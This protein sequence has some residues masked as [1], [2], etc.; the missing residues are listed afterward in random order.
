MALFSEFDLV[1]ISYDEPLKEERWAK[2]LDTVPW[3]KRV[4]GVK[5][6][7]AAHKA[8]AALSET[9]HFFT[10]DGDNEL[11]GSVHNIQVD[12]GPR[13]LLG[14]RILSWNAINAVNGLVYG[15]GGLKFWPKQLALDMRTHEAAE[16]QANGIEF[17]W[18]DRYTHLSEAFSITYPN[19]S[20][21]HAFRAGFREGVKMSLDRGSK[22][23]PGAVV[24]S[25]YWENLRR[26]KI[27]ASL[28]ADVQHGEW[29]IL[30]TRLGL[31]RV[32]CEPDFDVNL[33]RDYDWFAKYWD[34]L[35]FAFEDV[36]YHSY[37]LGHEL[38]KKIGLELSDF[39]AAQSKFVKYLMLKG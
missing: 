34:E 22:I 37:E 21:F 9:D 5:G 1:F 3:A 23:A 8:A 32:N 10:V 31:K 36:H 18:G 20:A 19:D 11:L 33:V 16:D 38:R 35:N 28:G 12:V 26:V 7:D 13:A 25:V 15:N 6:F 14:N 29:A 2:L 27:W 39:D 24:K 4:D 17:C 30:G